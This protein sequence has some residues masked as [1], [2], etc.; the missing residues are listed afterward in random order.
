MEITQMDLI[1]ANIEYGARGT[2]N[3]E[4]TQNILKEWRGSKKILDM[5]EADK[6]FRIQ[7]TAIDSKTRSYEDPETGILVINKTL[8]NTKSK[9]GKYRKLVNGRANF[10]L[11]KPFVISCDDDKYKEAWDEFLDEDIRDVISRIGKQAINKGISFAYP[12]IDVEGKLQIIDTQSETIYPAWSDIAHKRLDAVV[13]D[14]TVKEYINQ[15]SQDVH[16]VEFWDSKIFQKFIDY[17]RGE[18]S[19]D[20]Q[21]ENFEEDSELSQRVS[22]VNTHMVGK[23]GEGIS[24]DRVP[25]IPFKGSDDELPALNECRDNIDNYDLIKSKGIDSILDDIDAVLVVEDISPELNELA[26]ARKIIQNSRIVSVEQGGDARF[27]KVDTD[28]TAI[29]K[30]LDI[31]NKDIIN[32]TNLVDVTTIEFGSNPSGKAMR[33]FFE[34]LNEWANGFEKEFKAFM[35]GLKYFFDKWLSWKGGYGTFEELQKKKVTFEL[36]RDMIIDETDII[37]NI[38]KLQDELSQETRDELNPYIDNPEKEAKRRDDDFKKQQER[39]ELFNLQHD[40]DDSSKNQDND[41]KNNQN[42]EDN[43]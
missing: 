40:I 21:D 1:N 22:V 5:L 30:Q 37:D 20:L 33:M 8:S 41:S 7:N 14:Y 27:A 16:K 17:G 15:T 18:G 24:W 12:W 26:K 23:S 29:E 31:I 39:D 11:D 34:P 25:F 43:E 36:N 32:D 2:S 13:R 19:G 4:I 42:D 10:T 35:K 6:Y 3:K 38:I 28:I 9:T